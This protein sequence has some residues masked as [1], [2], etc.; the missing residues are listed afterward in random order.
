MRKS[1]LARLVFAFFL[2][3]CASS[4]LIFYPELPVDQKTLYKAQVALNRWERYLDKTYSTYE[5][6]PKRIKRKT[7]LVVGQLRRVSEQLMQYN[8]VAL[9]SGNAL[10]GSKNIIIGNNNAVYGNNN[11]IFTEDFNYAN[12]ASDPSKPINNHLV[13]DQWV[14]ELDRRE[15]IQDKLHDVIYPFK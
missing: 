14:A 6:N 4:A 13:S 7:D 1:I 3:Y 2:L 11:Y 15:Q 12:T 8:N 10:L 5:E 9:G